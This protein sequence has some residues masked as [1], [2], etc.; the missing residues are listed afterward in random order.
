MVCGITVGKIKPEPWLCG[1]TAKTW[2]FRS[3]SLLMSSSMRNKHYIVLAVLPITFSNCSAAWLLHDLPFRQPIG[4]WGTSQDCLQLKHEPVAWQTSWGTVWLTKPIEELANVSMIY[5]YSPFSISFA[6]V[7]E[8]CVGY[9]H[10]AASTSQWALGGLQP[11]WPLHQSLLNCSTRSL[12]MP[13][14]STIISLTFMLTATR[15]SQPSSSKTCRAKNCNKG[16]NCSRLLKGV[17]PWRIWNLDTYCSVA[18]ST[19]V[20]HGFKWRS[21]E[22]DETAI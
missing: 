16:S 10:K 5:T 3:M 13:G 15:P 12:K 6:L 9:T 22:G 8:T 21:H 1:I 20:G 4:D 7:L 18:Q 17:Q 2:W 11:T 14:I 19:C